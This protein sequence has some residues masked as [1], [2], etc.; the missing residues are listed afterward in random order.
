MTASEDPQRFPR[1]LSVRVSQ[2]L[3]RMPVRDTKPELRVRSAL[4][5]LGMR[6]RI[7]SRLPGR[8]DV[9]FT[10]ARLAVFV[11]GCFWHA[12]PTHGVLPKNNREWWRSKLSRNVERD[13]E[14]DDALRSLGWDVIHVWEH[15][16]ATEVAQ[17]IQVRWRQRTH[18]A[19]GDSRHGDESSHTT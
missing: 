11:D 7:T 16:D 12:C 6:F 18:V 13:R 8:P 17:H 10:R 2:Q 15:E 3:A 4:H 19:H 9:V 14:K 5:A 1:P